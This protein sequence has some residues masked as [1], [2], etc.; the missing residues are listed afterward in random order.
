MF[1][2][3]LPEGLQTFFSLLLDEDE[4]SLEGSFDEFFELELDSAKPKRAF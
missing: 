2:R 3:R 1:W 4:A